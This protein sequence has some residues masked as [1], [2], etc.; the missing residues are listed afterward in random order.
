MLSSENKQRSTYGKVRC[1]GQPAKVWDQGPT[2][3]WVNL[4]PDVDQVPGYA[5]QKGD[6]GH[7]FDGTLEAEEERHPDEV[8]A[9]LDGV[10]GCTLLH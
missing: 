3:Y 5:G 10:E 2:R 9:E 7:G 4:T 6:V 1:E 8:E